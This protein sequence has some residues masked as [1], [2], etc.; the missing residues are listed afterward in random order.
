M[1]GREPHNVGSPRTGT[2]SLS[3]LV[4]HGADDV[5]V[6]LASSK[7]FAATLTNAGHRVQLT[8]LPG[9]DHATI[10]TPGVIADTITTWIAS[11]VP[12]PRA[13]SS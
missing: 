3:V 4:A 10:Y 12:Q 5:E 8:I 6:S 13:A 11:L 2:D 9:V 7:N 1:E